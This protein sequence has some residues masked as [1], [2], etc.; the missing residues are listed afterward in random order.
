[1]LLKI[2]IKA[3]MNNMLSLNRRQFLKMLPGTSALAFPANSLF[4][5]NRSSGLRVTGISVTVVNV[6]LRTNWILVQLQTNQGITGLGEASLGSRTS[7]PELREFFELTRDSSPFAIA[8]FRQQGFARLAGQNRARATAFSAIEQALWDICGK[9]LEIPVYQ[10]FGGK[11]HDR[12]SV[13]ANINRATAQ[14]TPEGFAANAVAA[15][16]DGFKALKAA[17][18]DGFPA[19]DAPAQEITRATDLGIAA[20][21][22]MRDAVG[23]DIAIKIDAHSFFDVDLAIEVANQLDGA[24]LSWYEEPV[25]PTLLEQTVAIK[26]SIKQVMAG[27]E[28]LFGREG[29]RDLIVRRAVDII[30]PD[31]KHCGGAQELIQIATMAESFGVMVSPHNPSGPISTAASASLCAAM[32]NF[33]ILEFQWGEADWRSGLLQPAE[34]INNGLLPVSD[35][36]GWGITLN[37]ALLDSHLI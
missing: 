12:L 14:R 18:F 26:N 30:M 31:I 1:M 33:D 19:L 5:Q 15:A 7:L 27:G 24:N 32:P 34:Q 25:A 28:F 11:L 9:A 37:Q 36:P 20:V 3:L 35:A 22:A 10:F 23:P 21:Y 2:D 8:Q 29:F 16:T 4:A 17:P 6:T 13:Y